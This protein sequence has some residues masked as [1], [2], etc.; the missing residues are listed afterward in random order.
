MLTVRRI[1]RVV[2]AL[3]LGFALS[4]CGGSGNGSAASLQEPLASGGLG[5]IMVNIPTGSFTMGSP[6]TEPNRGTDEAPQHN[7]N[8]PSFFMGKYAVTWNEYLA[9]TTAM[10]RTPPLD[11]GFGQGIHPVTNVSWNDAVAYTQWLSTETG[12]TYRLPSEAE[13]EYANRA[14]TTTAYWWGPAISP[15]EANCTLGTIPN[16]CED[17]FTN[18][19]PVG[20]FAA[21]PFGLHD[22]L[23]NV[24]EWTADHWHADYIGAPSDGAPWLTSPDNNS[25]VLRGGSWADA[26]KNVR[27]A[28]RNWGAPTERYIGF[29]FRVSRAN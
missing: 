8:V 29:G 20:S 15:N 5:P 4:A 14:G 28:V 26:A 6:S 2:L 22:T 17:A 13:W 18:T 3:G 11:D 9:F 10:G 12:A 19:S 7:V 1:S 25:R 23:G 21:N 27:S 16:G 24:E